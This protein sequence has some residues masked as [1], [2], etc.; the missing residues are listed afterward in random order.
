MSF[1]SSPI[2]QALIFSRCYERLRYRCTLTRKQVLFVAYVIENG[3]MM[4]FAVRELTYDGI[5][6]DQAYQ[7]LTVL[8]RK[9]YATKTGWGTWTL[10]NAAYS[11]YKEFTQLY[12]SY[13]IQRKFWT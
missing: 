9:G 3:N 6:Y 7:Y 1:Y 2:R 13:D 5:S 11:F 12:K 8:R 4:S 10:T